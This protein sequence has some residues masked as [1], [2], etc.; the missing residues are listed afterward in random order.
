M[1]NLSDMK[2]QISNYV[3]SQMFCTQCG[4]KGIPIP[5]Q[6]NHLRETG[7]LKRL[8]CVSCKKVCN[9]AEMSV[10]YTP[11]DFARDFKSK[12]FQGGLYEES[13]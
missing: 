12:K 7:H 6:K 11:Q 5:R 10:N 1:I 2:R 9:F 8:Y 4:A 3:S 13:E